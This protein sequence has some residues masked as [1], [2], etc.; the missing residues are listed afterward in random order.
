MRDLLHL[1]KSQYD[2]ILVDTPPILPLSDMQIF[3]EVVDG[4][5]LVVRA[6]HTPKAALLQA[7][8]KL[9]TEKLVGIVL[10]DVALQGMSPYAY[11]YGKA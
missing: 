8:Q 10:N 9:G 6:E 3:A 7:I 2:F 5:L 1:L 4:V 11:A